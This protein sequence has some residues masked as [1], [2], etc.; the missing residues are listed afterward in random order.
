MVLDTISDRQ[1]YG[2]AAAVAVAAAFGA[3]YM[4]AGLTGSP[5][6]AIT[7]DAAS[8]DEIRDAVQ[9]AMDQQVQQQTQRLSLMAAQNPN[10]SADDLSMDASVTDVSPAEFGSLYAVTVSMT[11]TV[12]A[13]TGGTRTLDTD[14]TV[15]VTQDGRYLFPEPT[16]LEQPRQPPTGQR[17]PTGGQ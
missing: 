5:T 15:Y 6:G 7:A 4:G 16:D 13:R 3:G 10:L 9:S 2:L 14:R 17:A 11:G 8:T 12:P 1:R